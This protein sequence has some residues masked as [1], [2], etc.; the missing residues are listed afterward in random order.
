[1]KRI[2]I[3]VNK[4]VDWPD[5]EVA[6]APNGLDYFMS[7]EN[8]DDYLGI[9]TVDVNKG[10][11]Q[12]DVRK[13][14]EALQADSSK[15]YLGYQPDQTLSRRMFSLA[16]WFI[17]S[18]R[19]HDARTGLMAIPTAIFD[20]VS[21]SDSPLRFLVSAIQKKYAVEEVQVESEL[22][23]VRSASTCI[24]LWIL[25]QTFIKYVLSSFSS[26]LVDIVLFQLIIFLFGHLDSDI[27][28]LLATVISRVFSSVV[29]YSINK[30]VVF[31]N[32]GGHR[33]PALK[34]F[35]LVL[36]EMFTSAFLVAVVYRLTGFP[37]TAIKLL[38]DLVLFFTGYIIEKI[39]IFENTKND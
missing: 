27:R 22:Q 7:L 10:Y 14:M 15:I 31:Q 21:E 39:F 16:F 23:A 8:R 13:L 24:D 20:N 25:F 30:R 1:M 32:D 12:A 5:L 34:Y 11:T 6:L 28:I 2:L 38:V 35:S 26:F 3:V 4:Q 9:V 36:A 33:I 37:E 18:R 29:N 19:I 17:H